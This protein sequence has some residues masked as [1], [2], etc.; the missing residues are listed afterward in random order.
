MRSL[1]AGTGKKL[2]FRFWIDTWDEKNNRPSTTGA[3]NFVILAVPKDKTGA[4]PRLCSLTQATLSGMQQTRNV[5]MPN[6]RG[7]K[8]RLATLLDGVEGAATRGASAPEEDEGG[9]G[10]TGRLFVFDVKP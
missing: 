6:T 5:E 1:P 2:N 10:M 4:A 8:T 7:G 9:G 3:E